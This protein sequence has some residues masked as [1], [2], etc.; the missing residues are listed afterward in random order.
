[1][2]REI[3][4]LFE[5]I[6]RKNPLIHQITNLVTM[7]DCANVTL[8]AGASPVMAF[9]VE[10]AAEMAM[11]SNA[12]LINIG[13]L[14]PEA[15]EGMISAGKA[16][17]RMGIPVVFDPVGAG[18]TS[19]RTH[20]AMEIIREIKPIVIRGNA[21]EVDHLT[22][23]M[24]NT[25]GVDSRHITLSNTEIAEKAASTFNCVAVVS[26]KE[27]AVSDGKNTYLIQ[28]GHEL[29]TKVTGTGCM[30]TALIACFS[31]LDTDPLHSAIAGISLM[32]LAGEMAA[33]SLG[34]QEGLG[35]FKVRMMDF[36]SIIG[37]EMWL[38]GAKII[39][40]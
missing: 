22:G 17:N 18:A 33:A 40:A 5:E 15:Y 16:A 6:R 25:K 3:P 39:E 36:I 10:E 14:R 20:C 27:D 29:L 23:G 28:N 38:E 24:S 30:S 8:A 9:S 21:S 1:M 26:G 32:G 12:L 31:S 19:Y 11:K 37:G 35:S 34:K 7:N 2:K 13:T 4:K